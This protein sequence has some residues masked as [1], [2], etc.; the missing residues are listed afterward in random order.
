MNQRPLIRIVL[1]DDHPMT[2]AGLSAVIATRKDMCVV[3]EASN[4][5]EAIRLYQQLRPDVVLMDMWMP[6]MDGLQATRAIRAE[7]SAARIIVFSIAEGDETI[8]QAMKA[9]ARGYLLKDA[10]AAVLLETIQA[11]AEG[12]TVL[13]GEVAAKLAGRLHQRDLTKREQEILE[14][15]VAGRSNS[16]IGST[17][18]ISEGTVK[19]HV[20]S[21]LDKLHVTDRTQA[22]VSAIQRGLV[23]TSHPSFTD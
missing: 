4:G 23:R 6:N 3:G 22:A 16:E 2:R 18:F 14:H 20:N 21:L 19:S 10:P 17:L 12:H 7:C 5:C 11:V 8:Y 15:I 9:G 1:V 13:P